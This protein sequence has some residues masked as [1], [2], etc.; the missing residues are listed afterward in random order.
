MTT[1]PSAAPA[2]SAAPPI[3]PETLEGWYALHQF[4]SVD[5]ARARELAR[6]PGAREDA[7]RVLD[8]LAHPGSAGWTMVAPLVGSRADVGII[9]FRP[10]LDE[11]GAAQREVA[12]VPLLECLRPEY[13]FLSVTEA[14]M[15]QATLK[16]ARESAE[17]GGKL[18]DAAWKARM[19]ELLDAELATPHVQSRLYPPLPEQLPYVCFYPMSKKREHGQNWYA[20]ELAERAKLMLEHGLTGRRYAGRVLQ[21]VTG[22]MGLDAWEWGVTLFARDPLEF[23][24]IV[25]EMRFDEASAK[26]GEFGEFFVGKR[27]S[28]SEW[29]GTL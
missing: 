29:V 2:A 24:K 5:R 26:Y 6:E 9:H 27:A 23:K 28:A 13:S 16:V 7:V 1:P 11:I 14:G 10:T 12:S 18:A 17:R 25:A 19:Q 4:F 22:A 8:A 3:A 15:Y 21:I 20:L